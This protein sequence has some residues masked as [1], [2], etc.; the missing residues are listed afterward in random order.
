[1]CTVKHTLWLLSGERIGGDEAVAGRPARRT[2]QHPGEMMAV[3]TG[4]KWAHLRDGLNAENATGN[5]CN[6]ICSELF[7]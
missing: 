3:E 2:V 4:Q 6:D 5:T 7:T 1:M